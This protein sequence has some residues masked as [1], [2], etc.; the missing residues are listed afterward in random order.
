MWG[1]MGQYVYP[2][3]GLAGILAC[4]CLHHKESA[5]FGQPALSMSEQLPHALLSAL[6]A[7]DMEQNLEIPEQED[8]WRFPG[9]SRTLCAQDL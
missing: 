4:P 5:P 3:A 8:S 1:E 6:R 2:A 9:F 7:P